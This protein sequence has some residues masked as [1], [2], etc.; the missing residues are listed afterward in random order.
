MAQ[1]Y[2]LLFRFLAK[3]ALAGIAIRWDTDSLFEHVESGVLKDPS[4]WRSVTGWFGAHANGGVKIRPV[5]YCNPFRDYR[6]AVRVTQD[7]Y[8]AANGYAH[9]MVGTGYDLLDIGG[10]GLRLRWMHSRHKVICSRLMFQ[11]A[12]AA[13]IQTLNIARPYSYLVTPDIFHFEPFL[14]GCRV[15]AKGEPK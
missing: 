4:D 3:H 7:Q 8:R 10:L 1:P 9:R 14:R 12:D 5:D 2:Y 6:Y 11:M 15:M 13:G